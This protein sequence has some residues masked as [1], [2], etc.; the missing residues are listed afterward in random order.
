MVMLATQPTT[1]PATVPA[2]VQATIRATVGAT[3]P[4]T[5]PATIAA[6]AIT[7][8]TTTPI[9]TA[10]ATTAAPTATVVSPTK[11]SA[12][13]A[14]ANVTSGVARCIPAEVA[15][16]TTSPR[17]HV[18]CT[19]P[20]NNI[21]YFAVG[22]ADAGLADRVLQVALSAFNAGR[23]LSIAYDPND[24]SGESM[25]C[26]NADCRLIISVAEVK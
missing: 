4:A 3:L 12:A 15:V 25:G 2:T 24:L 10:T 7:T 6:T 20:T 14:A 21:L 8:M 19:S 23:A 1:V 17:I 9:I 26:L 11:T 22:T 13:T 16:F 5:V 18:K